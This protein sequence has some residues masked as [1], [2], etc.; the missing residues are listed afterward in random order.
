M[1]DKILVTLDGSS[2]AEKVLPYVEQIAAKFDSEIIL[3]HVVTIPAISASPEANIIEDEKIAE[4]HAQE[5][6]ERI[7]YRLTQAG[8]KAR[9]VIVK[10]K[11][12]E[13]IV[14][15]A[16]LEKVD[17]IAMSTHGRSGLGRWVFGSVAERV[18]RGAGCP[19]L[20]IRAKEE[21]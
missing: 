19:V 13:G 10:G 2:L 9:P 6:L 1:F 20:L 12:A 7:D 14:D 8:L 15:Y 3:L 18:L 21:E 11:P 17:L 5:Y 16:E 4:Q